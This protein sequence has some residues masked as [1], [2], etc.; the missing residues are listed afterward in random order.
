MLRGKFSF[1]N[2]IDLWRC[3]GLSKFWT[4]WNMTL[5][6]NC[7]LPKIKITL[8][9]EALFS[10]AEKMLFCSKAQYSERPNVSFETRKHLFKEAGSRGIKTICCGTKLPSGF[11][12]LGH[13]LFWGIT[14]LLNLNFLIYSVTIIKLPKAWGVIKTK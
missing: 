10:L 14:M 11:F 13:F 4:E 8:H 6:R 3:I 9:K 2:P 1:F 7:F 5:Y 12:L